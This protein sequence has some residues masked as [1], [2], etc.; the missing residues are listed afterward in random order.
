MWNT[1][2]KQNKNKDRTNIDIIVLETERGQLIAS[3]L[4]LWHLRVEIFKSDEL[5]GCKE[6]LNS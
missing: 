6:A 2:N 4:L 3:C 1:D 5:I